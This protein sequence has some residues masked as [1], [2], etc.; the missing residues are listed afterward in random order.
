MEERKAS[1]DINDGRLLEFGA[2]RDT[3]RPTQPKF[4]A[5][6]ST[7]SSH[8]VGAQHALITAEVAWLTLEMMK[9]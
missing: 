7:F 4:A 8:F 3:K 1:P 9:K 2:A 5:H 6:S